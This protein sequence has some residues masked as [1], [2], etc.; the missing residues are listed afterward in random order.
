MKLR[1][2]LS[3]LAL[4]T[5]TMTVACEEKKDADAEAKDDGDKKA[6]GDK[7]DKKGGDADVP[8]ACADYFAAVDKCMGAM[9]AEAKPAMEQ[10][11]KAI[12]DG[13]KAAKKAGGDSAKAYEKSCTAAHDAIKANPACK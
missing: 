8:K 9:P 3:V 4:A 11:K 5:A 7:K 13:W 10:G 1:I 2:L 6:D 12:E